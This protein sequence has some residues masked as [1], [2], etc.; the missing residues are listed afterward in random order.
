MSVQIRNTNDLLS[1]SVGL[2]QSRSGSYVRLRLYRG[3]DQLEEFRV[4]PAD[5]GVPAS[6]SLRH[7]RSYPLPE[8]LP[9][10]LLEPIAASAA[11]HRQDLEPLWLL[12]ERSTPHLAV[13]PWERMLRQKIDFPILRIPNL[14]V[15][16]IFLEGE[17]NLVVCASSPRAKPSFDVAE[18]TRVVVA[19][20][21]D[22]VPAGC[23]IHVFCDQAY[24]G[25]LQ[26]IGGKGVTVYDPE[27][28]AQYDSGMEEGVIPEGRG[29]LVSPWL[30]WMSDR[31]RRVPVDAVHFVCPGF[32]RS[33]QGALALAQ[34]PT[35]N[36]NRNWSHFVGVHELTA[37]LDGV[38]A[39][40]LG[41]SAP[42]HDVWVLGLRLLAESL[43][44]SR[45]GPVVLD[46]FGQLPSPGPL[47]EAFRFLY[48]PE[49]RDSPDCPELTIYC[50][51]RR[52]K[53]Y[54]GPE[55]EFRASG[56]H[57]RSKETYE[58]YESAMSRTQ[59]LLES[60]GPRARGTGERG[61]AGGPE[62]WRQLNT[63]AAS[64]ERNVAQ[65]ANRLVLDRAIAEYSKIG[66]TG[67]TDSA[68]ADGAANAIRFVAELL[69]EPD[70]EGD[71]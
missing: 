34:S 51:P 68:R 33:D 67:S 18:A 27:E 31:L 8:S 38:A 56:Q 23:R 5:I 11:G 44:Y 50:H 10:D 58:V 35:Y 39:W 63:V 21:R 55:S 1:L 24:H 41:L 71:V 25:E 3:H 14:A 32:F 12:L 16:P 19:A 70:D 22:S 46:D 2:R 47:A 57:L 40:S 37:F 13:L 54:A 61:A 45:P 60:M 59:E 52:L 42:R 69:S 62:Q 4:Q 26:G 36:R 64:T 9:L 53:E 48:A 20:A 7:L 30:R 17:L 65:Q 6:L 43:T 29:G 66:V 28:A 15:D 49:F